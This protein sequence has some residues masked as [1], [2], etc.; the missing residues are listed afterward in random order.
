MSLPQPYAHDPHRRLP[1]DAGA[2]LR[3]AGREAIYEPGE[4]LVRSFDLSSDLFLL[5]SGLAQLVG[6]LE[7]GDPWTLSFYHPGDF[8]DVASLDQGDHRSYEVVAVTEVV[9]L[10]V[11]RDRFL[12]LGRRRPE[13]LE[14]ALESAREQ[15]AAMAGLALEGRS[16]DVQARLAHLLF[17]LVRPED[18]SSEELV[19]LAFHLSH[20]E[21]AR[22]VGASRP[23]V[24]AMLKKMEQTD[25]VRR[26]GQRG[27]QVRPS[28]LR[29]LLRKATIA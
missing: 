15:A 25:A 18:R 17:E 29:R 24:S 23:H 5:D 19:P 10:A 12:A 11:G 28:G 7:D 26:E 16:L 14:A 2:A 13:I 20:E 27:V 4:R 21:M 1:P 8:V 3:D 22:F 9:A 6:M